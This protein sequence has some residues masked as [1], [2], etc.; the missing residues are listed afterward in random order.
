MIVLITGVAGAGK[1]TVGSALAERLGCEFLDADSLHPAANVAKMHAGIPLTDEDR[2]PWLHA[3]AGAIERFI[4][5]GQCAVVACSALKHS[6]RELLLQPGVKMVYLKIDPVL[7]QWRAKERHH[8][9]MPATL[10]ASQFADLEE[11]ADAFVV[12]A[13]LPVEESV[14]RI[15]SWLR[16][17]SG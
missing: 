17:T 1:T 16:D 11:P 5:S 6:Y 8:A 2:W 7:A 14:K 10:V 15:A 4:R 3:V 12:P 9:F 13:A